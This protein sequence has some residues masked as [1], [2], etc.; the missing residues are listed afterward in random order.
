MEN[1]NNNNYPDLFELWSFHNLLGYEESYAYLCSTG[2]Y[3]FHVRSALTNLSTLNTLTN[4]G[5]MKLWS[6]IAHK[7]FR[8]FEKNNVRFYE[9]GLT[10]VM[11]WKRLFTAFLRFF[12]APEGSNK[13]HNS[14]W[15]DI[16]GRMEDVQDCELLHRLMKDALFLFK[17]YLPQDQ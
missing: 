11:K 15:M 2:F 1:N 5:V 13:R 17:Y 12:E 4:E 10:P 16:L 8:I 7:V 3:T 6:A 9:D 14:L